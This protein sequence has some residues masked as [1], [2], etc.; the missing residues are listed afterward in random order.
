[1]PLIKPGDDL[2]AMIA[3]ATEQVGGLRDEDIIV[4]SSKV[5]AT[6][7]GRVR[8]LARV[9]PSARAKK[10]AAKSG[11][12]PEFVELVL[13]EAG[14]VLNISKNVI[15]TLKSG[16]ICANAGVDNSNVPPGHVVLMPTNPNRVAR[17]LQRAIEQRTNA[18]V[19][20]IITDSNVKPLRLGTVGQ[21]IGVTGLEPVVDCRGQHDLYGK[22]LRITFRALAD[23]LATAAQAVMGEAAEG[24]PV[25][26]VRGAGVEF[27]EKPKRSP[28][29]SPKQCIYF[30]G[31]KLSKKS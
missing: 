10:I 19:G 18:R 5:V 25:V 22:P 27:V 3:R 9:R 23:Q 6:V 11:Q 14:S 2:S 31:L 24:V 28:K 13:R 1:M 7:Q 29:I 17:E 16:V 20:V 26:V 15:L 30:N 8:E 4:I 12:D 21:A